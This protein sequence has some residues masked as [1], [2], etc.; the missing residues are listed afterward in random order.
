MLEVAARNEHNFLER[1]F[2]YTNSS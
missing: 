2:D 1:D